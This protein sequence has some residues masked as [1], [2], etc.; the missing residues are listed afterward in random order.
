MTKGPTIN[1]GQEYQCLTSGDAHTS[2]KAYLVSKGHVWYWC[3]A[4]KC[5]G[6]KWK[7]DLGQFPVSFTELSGIPVYSAY[8]EQVT[9][10]LSREL[11]L[12]GLPRDV[13]DVLPVLSDTVA[14]VAC[15]DVTCNQRIHIGVVFQEWYERSDVV[16]DTTLFPD[17]DETVEEARV[18][19]ATDCWERFQEP[20]S[21]SH[22]KSLADLSV[23][24]NT[25]DG[26]ECVR[27]AEKYRH[28]FDRLPQS[29][30]PYAQNVARCQVRS[31]HFYTQGH[32]SG[33][34]VKRNTRQK[35]KPVLPC[36]KICVYTLLVPD[37]DPSLAHHSLAWYHYK[38]GTNSKW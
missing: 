13:V 17:I 5:A 21:S 7:V 27:S 36:L 22:G 29:G 14:T 32:T 2:N 9:R 6:K 23:H 8:A 33:A 31:F 37:D 20:T 11:V 19:Q 38:T 3:Y 12:Q 1:A 18:S 35:N 4:E 26:R 25:Q 34:R 28:S 30:A 15:G 10:M 16:M 24:P